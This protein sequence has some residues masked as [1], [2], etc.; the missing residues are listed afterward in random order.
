MVE[1]AK[2][3]GQIRGRGHRLFECKRIKERGVILTLLR[4]V[5]SDKALEMGA[6]E[7]V[8][9]QEGFV[10]HA[11]MFEIYL[12]SNVRTILGFNYGNTHSLDVTTKDKIKQISF[13]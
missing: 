11:I 8:Y 9:V 7:D 1:G 6:G 10:W 3:K 5:M 12:V 4:V 13:F 2:K